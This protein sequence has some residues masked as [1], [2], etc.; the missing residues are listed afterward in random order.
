MR[1]GKQAA[2][3]GLPLRVARRDRREGGLEPRALE[4][5][6]RRKVKTR[7]CRPA[8]GADV[9]LRD[10]VKTGVHGLLDK[11]L[12]TPFLS[13]RPPYR[14][15]PLIDHLLFLS[16]FFVSFPNQSYQVP[17]TPQERLYT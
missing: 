12:S 3:L 6:Q 8:L 4:E 14:V 10:T 16:F 13:F 5:G 15:I 1:F 7:A 17:I 11:V 2:M 9:R